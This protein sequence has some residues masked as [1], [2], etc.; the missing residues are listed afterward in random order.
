MKYNF[1]WMVVI[2]IV[3]VIF[4]VMAYRIECVE[5]YYG[6]TKTVCNFWG[7]RHAEVDIDSP[8]CELK[9]DICIRHTACFLK[10]CGG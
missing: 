5:A 1:S 2:L 10:W 3:L 6:C 4:L 9:E 8:Q 7:C